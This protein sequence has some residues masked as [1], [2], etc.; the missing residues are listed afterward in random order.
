MDGPAPPTTEVGEVAPY[1]EFPVGDYRAE[2]RLVQRRRLLGW[3][4]GGG[5]A[6]VCA[7]AVGFIWSGLDSGP[8][9]RARQGLQVTVAASFADLRSGVEATGAPLYIQA[10]KAFITPIPA[11]LVSSAVTAYDP[12][13]QVGVAAGLVAF[14][15]GCPYDGI[16][17]LYCASSEWFECLGCGSQFTMYGEK[18][19]GPAPR[20][21]T[22]IALAESG[23][24]IVID[25]ERTAPVSASAW[26]SAI[27][28]LP[29]RTASNI[30]T[31]ANS[32][33]SHPAARGLTGQ[34]GEWEV[35][36]AR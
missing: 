9:R 14:S 19:G 16:Q 20:G 13:V 27:S 34:P 3:A 23:N 11:W 33:P 28:R 17:L 32:P 6:A 7:S 30:E 26:T 5:L 21:M 22:L 1:P 29:D 12:V 4:V 10:A 35:L 2:G 8:A 31:T 25:T 36:T 15:Q 18:R 24:G